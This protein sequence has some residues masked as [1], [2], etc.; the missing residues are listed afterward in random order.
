MT[1]ATMTITM[2]IEMS[3]QHIRTFLTSS[4]SIFMC[5]SCDKN[6]AHRM[7]SK[8]INIYVYRIPFVLTRSGKVL[9]LMHCFQI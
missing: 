9:I 8:F 5:I 4:L 1:R 2:I 7:I 6:T 3:A